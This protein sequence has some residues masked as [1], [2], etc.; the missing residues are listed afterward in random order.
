MER[1][2]ATGDDALLVLSAKGERRVSG[3]LKSESKMSENIGI[4]VCKLLN[5]EGVCID[6]SYSTGNPVKVDFDR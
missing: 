1:K 6:S 3:D 2:E 4:D 5:Y